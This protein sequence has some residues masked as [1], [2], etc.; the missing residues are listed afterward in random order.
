MAELRRHPR[1]RIPT[2]VACAFARMGLAR[3][4]AEQRAG[5]GVILD[6]SLQ[7]ARV[8]SQ[9][10]MAPGDQL[11]VSLRIPDQPTVMH[12]DATVRWKSEHVFGVEF[13]QVSTHAATRLQ[14]YLS[15]ASPVPLAS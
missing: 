9:V 14:K 3:W 13:A 12:V 2:P 7:G 10:A 1:L 8:M 15:K 6:L 11:A 5:Y 4:S